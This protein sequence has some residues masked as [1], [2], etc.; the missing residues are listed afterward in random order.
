MAGQRIDIMELRSLVVL[1]LKGLYDLKRSVSF[2]GTGSHYEYDTTLAFGDSFNRS[3]NCYLL[4]AAGLSASTIKK[5]VLRGYLFSCWRCY[6][7]IS[8]VFLP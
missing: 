1:K 4:I 6:A 7:L 2:P 8:F 5:V 3:V